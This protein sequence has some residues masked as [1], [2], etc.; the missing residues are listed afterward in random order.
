M[1]QR[2]KQTMQDPS[3]NYDK[4]Y[5]VL[6]D[7]KLS[8]AEKRKVL[9]NW[10]DEVQHILESESENMCA[11]GRASDEEEVLQNITQALNGLR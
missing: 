11:E 5:D 10:A 4:P 1:S 8:Q 9:R 3:D 6:Q 2:L 7:E